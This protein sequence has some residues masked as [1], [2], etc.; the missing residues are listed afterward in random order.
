MLKKFL[1]TLCVLAS[2]LT[3]MLL[4]AQAA[5]S[6][7]CFYAGYSRV[8]INPYVIDGDFSSGIMELPLRGTGDVWNRLSKKM[9][10]DNGDG[11]VTKEDGLKATCIA[12]SDQ[13]GNTVLLITID[14]IGGTMVS[15]VR[16]EV[17][18]R[19]EDTGDFVSLLE[20]GQEI[21]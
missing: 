10:D 13:N 6:E 12:V 14:L 4:P 11:K 19:M 21:L 15:E 5:G 1:V 8:D 16:E 7:P 9:V 18:T 17:Y 2:L 3:V 20:I